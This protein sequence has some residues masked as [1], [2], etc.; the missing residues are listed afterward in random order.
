MLA[1]R[2]ADV[3]DA[4]DVRVSDL[5]SDANFITEPYEPKSIRGQT[6]RQEFQG[7]RLAQLK[8]IRAIH[9]AHAAFTQPTDDAIPPGPQRARSQTL[10]SGIG[11]LRPRRRI[12]YHRGWD[13][14]EVANLRVISKQGLDTHAKWQVI[15]AGFFEVRGANFSIRQ[16]ECRVEDGLFGMLLIAH[17]RSDLCF[18]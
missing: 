4:A 7:D 3:I 8:I 18:E 17:G 9:L 11:S 12:H 5:P 10:L 6:M 15:A 14:H 2:L 1:L 13:F 16:L